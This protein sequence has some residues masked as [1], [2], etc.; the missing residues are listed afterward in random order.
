METVSLRNGGSVVIR[1]IR[2]DDG[3]RLRAAYDRLSP[4]S[5]YRR[6]L[7]PKPHLSESEVR[8]LVEIDGANHV[9]LIATD[10]DDPERLIGVARFVRLSDDPRTAEFAIVVGDP[11]QGQGVGRALMD[12]LIESGRAHGIERFRATMLADNLPAHRL[13]S[14]LAGPQATLGKR[15]TVH[16]LDVGLTARQ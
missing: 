3:P 10:A 1:P 2:P 14:Q 5:R 13:V 8:Y 9:A 12:K 11:W 16:E 7:A 4:E 6:F 15:G